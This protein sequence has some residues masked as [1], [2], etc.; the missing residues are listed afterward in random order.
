MTSLLPTS[1]SAPTLEMV[2]ALA[3]VSRSTVS[4]VVNASPK[5]TPEVVEIVNAAIVTLGYVPNRAAR[6]LASRKTDSIALVIPEN[7][8]KFFADPFFAS[9]IQGAAMF[10]SKTDYTLT[11]LIAS[12]TDAQKTQRYLRGGNVDGALVLSH[13][14]DD[15]SYVELGQNFPIVFGGRPMS[16]GGRNFV[17]DVDNVAAAATAVQCLIDHGKTNIATIAGPQDMAAGLDRLEGWRTT[18]ETAGLPA[19]LFEA[20]DF[21][22]AG[23]ASAMKRLLDRGERF[24]GLFAASAQMAS[25]ALGVLREHGLAV[26]GDVG[27]TTI[28]NDYYAKNANPPLTTVDQPSMQQGAKMAEV[29]VRMIDGE[30]VDTLTI[31]PTHLIERASV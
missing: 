21:T 9:V 10:L 19:T 8:A 15:R 1:G 17:V 24:D 3:G 4:R 22:P 18:L 27:V 14:S 31:M 7:T 2:A 16:Q 6:T 29:L 26:P 28:D 12:E 11:L 30:D 25:G 23:G 13:H 5:V 20:A